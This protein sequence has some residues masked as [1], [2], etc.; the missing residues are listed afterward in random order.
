MPQTYLSVVG[1]W[2]RD[3]VLTGDVV[4]AVIRGAGARARGAA[5]C[6]VLATQIKH[7]LKKDKDSVGKKTVSTGRDCGPQTCH[8]KRAFLGGGDGAVSATQQRAAPPLA[9]FL[10]QPGAKLQ[11]GFR[12][13]TQVRR[14]LI[15]ATSLIIY[16]PLVMHKQTKKSNYFGTPNTSHLLILI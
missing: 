7:I 2:H 9:H 3:A 11:V 5:T 10:L 16:S 13:W 14:T 4:G 12:G 15:N 8:I 1:D 6:R